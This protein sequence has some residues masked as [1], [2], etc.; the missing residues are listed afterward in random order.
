VMAVAER[1]GLLRVPAH[2]L[3]EGLERAS[4]VSMASAAPRRAPSTART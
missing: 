3:D 1:I 2:A 4:A